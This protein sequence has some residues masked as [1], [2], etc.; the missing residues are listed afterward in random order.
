MS[1]LG[2]ILFVAVVSAGLLVLPWLGL[3]DFYLN[4]ICTIGLNY[5]AAAGLNILVGY[6]GQ[7]SLGHAGLFAVG[8]YTAAIANVTFGISPWLA[9]PL[10]CLMGALAGF[11]I[12]APSVRVSGPSLAM[13]TIGFGIVVEKIV[14][15]WTD[16]FG[17]QAGIYG[18]AP[19]SLLGHSPTNI[20]WVMIV[21]VLSM[22]TYLL[23]S[24]LIASRF[25]RAL[26]AVQLAEPAALSVGI[27]VTRMKTVAF[28]VSAVTCALTGALVA[29]KNQYIN[30]DF[31]TFD[32]SVFLLVVVIFGGQSSRLGPV[33]GAVVLTVLDA[34]LARW[35]A[36]Q[37]F[38]FGLLLLFALYLMPNGIAGT[39]AR[40][41]PA[42]QGKDG[43]AADR[44]T[45]FGRSVARTPSTSQPLLKVENLF[46][47][48]GGIVPV[49]N[50]SFTITHGKVHALIGPNG[51]GKTTLLNLL[52]GHV[53]PDRGSVRLDG[54]ELARLPADRVAAAGIARTF[55]NLK[56]F[57]HMSVLDNV[58]VGSHMHIEGSL[59]AS[60]LGSP[61]SRRSEQA[62]RA[63]ALALLKDLGMAD[64]AQDRASS[65]PYGLQRR[66]EIARALATRPRLLLLD[67]PAAGLNPQETH[68][69]GGVIRRIQESGITVLLIEHH[70]DLVMGISDH[71]LVLDYGQLISE[72]APDT[73][74]RNPKVIE[75]Y[76][77]VEE[78]A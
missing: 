71:V 31:I 3:N 38:T 43:P 65:L 55:Q 5:L 40:F 24:S 52:S 49:N 25:G 59:A 37:H 23:L 7:K 16:L 74:R 14:T 68:E 1:R 70:M 2:D 56:L 20:Q 51:A 34:W 13:V 18:I 54:A 58:L 66:L 6:A 30:S 17:G 42:R 73:I 21:G 63:D 9:L 26:M 64:R 8:A 76:L 78:I 29:Q 60:L 28:V 45:A 67:E 46:K 11:V 75:A 15:E 32:L 39:L 33:L 4:I 53:R 62:A 12:A 77:G 35:P 27:S 48:Y 47:A 72:G 10:A 22:A 69:L 61:A 50:V 41:L 57:G 36:L 44:P 19:P